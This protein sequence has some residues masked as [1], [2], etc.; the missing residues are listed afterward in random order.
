MSNNNFLKISWFFVIQK[1]KINSKQTH[2]VD[3]SLNQ[4]MNNGFKEKREL[5]SHQ[6]FKK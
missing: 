2:F 3:E 4:K 6:H 1:I 5:N